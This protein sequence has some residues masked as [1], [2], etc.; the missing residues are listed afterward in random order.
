M[1]ATSFGQNDN[2][3]THV[4]FHPEPDIGAHCQPPH[5]HFDVHTRRYRTRPLIDDEGS[6]MTSCNMAYSSYNS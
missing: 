5:H 3:I 6:Q 2:T 1:L 4:V